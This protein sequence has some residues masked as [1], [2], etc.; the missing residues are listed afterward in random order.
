M[1]LSAAKSYAIF[2]PAFPYVYMPVGDYM[3]WMTTISTQYKDKQINCN[4][5]S[6]TKCYFANSCDHVRNFVQ[7]KPQKFELGD[8]NTGSF[9]VT[10]DL[11]KLLIPG[12]NVGGKIGQC[13]IGMFSSKSIEM[14]T[15]YIGNIVMEEYYVVY[16]ATPAEQGQ[17]WIQ[18][19]IAPS[20]D[21]LLWARGAQQNIFGDTVIN[22]P[23]TAGSD[24]EAQKNNT[25]VIVLLFVLS[26][27]GVTAGV[28]C[29]KK[30]KGGKT[31]DTAGNTAIQ[32]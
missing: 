26:I 30:K 5:L 17:D 22:N 18:L 16:D 13:Y 9:T 12:Q 3:R 14:D 6:G 2:E 11:S 4:P 20:V 1:T 25:T 23:N 27:I 31:F 19:G 8:S 10:M 28:V 21:K 7:M 29:Y 15:W 32:Q 24:E